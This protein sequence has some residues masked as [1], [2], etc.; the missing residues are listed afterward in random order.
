MIKI[1]VVGAAGRMGGRIITAVKEAEGLELAGAV[2]RPG[3]DMIGQ[4]AGI[5]AGC[6]SLGVA[7]G[8]SLEQA[9]ETSDVLIDF[10]FPEVTL[11]NL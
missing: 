7:I 6:G 8:G 9:M 1:A 3:H 5:V 11:Q 10:T 2:E 4:D